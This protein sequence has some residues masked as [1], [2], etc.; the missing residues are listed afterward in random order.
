MMHDAWDSSDSDEEFD[1]PRVGGHVIKETIRW[2]IIGALRTMLN[3]TKPQ[4]LAHG[5]QS[6]VAKQFGVTQGFVSKLWKRFANQI[7]A[8]QLLD[9][10]PNL[11][12]Y[13]Q[14]Q[15][16]VQHDGA[17]PH[18]GKGN[19]VLLDEAGQLQGM[20]IARLVQARSLFVFKPSISVT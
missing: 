13:G 5:A 10:A 9:L 3:T 19:E 4:A 8:G 2:A 20:N 11:A 17:T 15:I 12:S 18:T 14:R 6:L 7:E 1:A 16:V